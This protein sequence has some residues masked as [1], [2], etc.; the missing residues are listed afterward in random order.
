M[1]S[2]TYEVRFSEDCNENVVIF[3]DRL[4][5]SVPYMK[6]SKCGKPIKRTMFTVQSVKDC[7]ELMYLGS[8]CIKNLK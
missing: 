4:D 3:K 7:V 6:C 5:C 8:E 1:K 2:T